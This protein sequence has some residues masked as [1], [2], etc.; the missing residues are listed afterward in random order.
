MRFGTFST[1]IRNDWPSLTSIL[2]LLKGNLLWENQTYT[3]FSRHELP[4][5]LLWQNLFVSQLFFVWVCWRCRSVCILAGSAFNLNQ[6][7]GGSLI[8]HP[9]KLRLFLILAPLWW[10]LVLGLLIWFILHDCPFSWHNIKHGSRPTI[11]TSNYRMPCRLAVYP[12]GC[13]PSL[14]AL[15]SP[16]LVSLA[17]CTHALFYTVCFCFGWCHALYL[18][19]TVQT[20]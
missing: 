14:Y 13:F 5:L 1:L 15:L 12:A 3:G 18:W 16:V 19:L 8:L 4:H 11:G 20:F 6:L 7:L 2:L 17:I 9:D 10:R